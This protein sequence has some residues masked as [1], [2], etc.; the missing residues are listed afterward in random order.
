M[1]WRAALV[2]N[3]TEFG[4]KII[5]GGTTDLH[6]AYF[7]LG[8]DGVGAMQLRDGQPKWFNAPVRK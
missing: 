6:I 3:T 8:Q 1:I 2:A 5:W 7:G 4:G